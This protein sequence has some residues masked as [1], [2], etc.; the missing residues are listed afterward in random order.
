MSGGGG[1][2]DRGLWWRW[3]LAN[4]VGLGGGLALLVGLLVSSGLLSERLAVYR[5]GAL[6]ST[7]LVVPLIPV[8]LGGAMGLAQWLTLRRRLP[9]LGWWAPVTTLTVALVLPVALVVGFIGSQVVSTALEGLLA[10]LVRSYPDPATLNPGGGV[11][12]APS[13]VYSR[14]RDFTFGLT[15]LVWDALAGGLVGLAL[16]WAQSR[17]LRRHLPGASGWLAANVVAVTLVGVITLVTLFGGLTLP[18]LAPSDPLAQLAPGLAGLLLF[19]AFPVAGL[20]AGAVGGAITGR[21]LVRLVTGLPEVAPVPRAPRS[22]RRLV[23]VVGLL[24]MC[25]LLAALSQTVGPGRRVAEVGLLQT[26]TC[27]ALFPSYPLGDDSA[28]PRRRIPPEADS[29]PIPTPRPTPPPP[30]QATRY[31]LA[32]EAGLPLL[33]VETLEEAP[34]RLVLSLLSPS[35]RQLAITTEAGVGVL[36]LATRERRAYTASIDWPLYWTDERSLFL[37]TRHGGDL[38]GGPYRLDAPTRKT[39]PFEERWELNAINPALF[40]TPL[41][42][43]WHVTDR[44]RVGEGEVCRAALDGRLRTAPASDGSLLLQRED[45]LAHGVELM[46]EHYGV[47]LTADEIGALRVGAQGGLVTTR[48]SSP[49]GYW[50][51]SGYMQ[52][53]WRRGLILADRPTT[54]RNVIVYLASEAHWQGYPVLAEPQ[55]IY[56]NDRWPWDDRHPRFLVGYSPC[57]TGQGGYRWVLYRKPTDGR[58]PDPVGVIPYPEQGWGLVWSPDGEYLYFD[59]TSGGRYSLSRLRLLTD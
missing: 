9:G 17:L 19:L 4:A 52:D 26:N 49:V 39:T 11:Y 44:L 31:D 20:V 3:T 10:P 18:S 5:L 36:D 25:V 2:M 16:G 38:P 40:P 59:Q 33:P 57:P 23:L 50:P 46:R 53:P 12:P 1:G 55:S 29:Q 32:C 8:V 56:V 51:D 43:A 45:V 47:F 48:L 27:Q 35:G 30:P 14:W 24:G 54:P 42:S 21:T 22:R 58:R 37:T 7:I 6:G 28:G 34:G 13:P 15:S 41:V